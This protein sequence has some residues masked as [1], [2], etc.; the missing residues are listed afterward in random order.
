M[1]RKIKKVTI[2]NDVDRYDRI[3]IY[4]EHGHEIYNRDS[5]GI[6]T[7]YD[8]DDYGNMIHMK[9]WTVADVENFFGQLGFSESAAEGVY[10]TLIE[11]PGTYACYGYGMKFFID[12][13]TSAQSKLGDIYDEVR[14]NEVIHSRGWVGL[15]ELQQIVDDYIEDTLYIYNKK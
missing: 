2:H 14:F 6:E 12:L 5:F 13:H 9:D 4:D 7:W 3:I 1:K 10:L 8:Y 11:M 15:E